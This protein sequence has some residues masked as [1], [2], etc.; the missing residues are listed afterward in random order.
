MHAAHSLVLAFSF[1]AVVA[2]DESVLGPSASL[3]RQF[4]LAPGET[5]HIESTSL[6][7][8][9]TGV[10]DDS[11]CPVDVDCIQ[12]GS[13]LVRITVMDGRARR[14]YELHT[15]DASPLRHG[16]LT[17]ALVELAPE[18]RSSR[19]IRPEDYRLILKATR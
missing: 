12:A 16:D 9:F 10:G 19:V 15:A 11:R 1:V 5:A 6:S 13:A 3:D 14:D 17:I 4:T 18:P 7:V 8:Q 2:C